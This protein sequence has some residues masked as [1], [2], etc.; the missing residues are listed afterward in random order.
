MAMAMGVSEVCVGRGS[1]P[2]V[3]PSRRLNRAPGGASRAPG[4]GLTPKCCVPTRGLTREAPG[5][6]EG[7]GPWGYNLADISFYNIFAAV[8]GRPERCMYVL[9]LVFF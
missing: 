6:P 4:G 1:R 2:R 7:G 5:V 3:G 9:L 8:W